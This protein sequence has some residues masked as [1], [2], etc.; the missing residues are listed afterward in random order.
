M[1]LVRRRAML[2]KN[3]QPGS[4]R[5]RREAAQAAADI[6]TKAEEHDKALEVVPVLLDHTNSPTRQTR[7]PSYFRT[8]DLRRNA[9]N[10][11]IT[12][13]RPPPSDWALFQFSA[14]LDIPSQ[15]MMHKCK[16]CLEITMDQAIA[17]QYRRLSDFICNPIRDAICPFELFHIGIDFGLDQLVCF[18]WL[19]FQKLSFHATVLLAY[20][21]EDLIFE[22]QLSSTA[23]YHLSRALTFLNMQLSEKNAFQ[24][25]VIIYVVSILA[26]VAILFGDHVAAATHAA[27]LRRIIRLRGGMRALDNNPLVQFSIDR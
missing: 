21:S 19:C 27:G 24:Q 17:E 14:E 12:V 3:K 22:Q 5:S 6:S 7:P 16:S 15:K 23:S 1:Q 8:G 9:V 13:P 18:R 10:T 2:G 26:S 20:A 25:D 4:R 11:R